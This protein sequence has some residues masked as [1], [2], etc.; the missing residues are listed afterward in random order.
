MEEFR[1]AM[2]DS[3]MMPLAFEV[4]ELFNEADTDGSG[5]VDFEEYCQF[6]QMYKAKQ[7]CCEI[8]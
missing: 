4:R 5:T 2:I 6:V 7:G 3:G 1:K 8:L